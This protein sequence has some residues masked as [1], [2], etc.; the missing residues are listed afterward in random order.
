MAVQDPN[1]SGL[2]RHDPVSPFRTLVHAISLAPHSFPELES[3][4]AQD[5]ET[6]QRLSDFHRVEALVNFADTAIPADIAAHYAAQRRVIAIQSLKLAHAVMDISESFSAQNIPTLLLKGHAVAARYYDHPERRQ[7]IDADFLVKSSDVEAACS[8]LEQLGFVETGPGAG[9]PARC[10]DVLLSLTNDRTYLRHGDGVQ[11]DLHW[12][13][14]KAETLLPWRVKDL[15]AEAKPLSVGKG[16][17]M[18][19]PLHKQFIYLCTHGAKHKWFRLKWLADIDRMLCVLTESDCRAIRA[20]A[21]ELGVWSMMAASL[22]TYE[23]IYGKTCSRAFGLSRVSA[24][25][26]RLAQA[27]Q[28]RAAESRLP[29]MSFRLVDLPMVARIFWQSFTLKASLKY[30]AEVIFTWLT[31]PR[32]IAVLRLPKRWLAIY[33]LLGPVLALRR[34]CAREI[35]A[36]LSPKTNGTGGSSS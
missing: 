36:F 9:C 12:R 16:S 1:P 27:M 15:L 33:A 18:V 28:E 23:A 3:Y 22:L 11:L 2:P 5:W 32:D 10:H 7:S 29:K 8:I 20:E 4:S 31:D 30:K 14:N 24:G 34:I 6:F 13:L 25:E 26:K 21:E 17:V 19:M 35:Q